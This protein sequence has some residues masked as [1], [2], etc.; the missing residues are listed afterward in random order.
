MHS[1][2]FEIIGHC[3]GLEVEGF[4]WKHDDLHIYLNQIAKLLDLSYPTGKHDEWGEEIMQIDERVSIWAEKPSRNIEELYEFDSRLPESQ[5]QG[6]RLKDW[7]EREPRPLPR[8]E[9]HP[10]VTNLFEFRLEDIVVKG[11]NP[12]PDIKGIP[13]LT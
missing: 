7:F 12:H 9:L 5:Q 4:L 11:Y 13:V 1:I 8:I 10:D 6:N 3:A 2:L